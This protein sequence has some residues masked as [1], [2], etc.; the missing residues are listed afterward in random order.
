MRILL[1]GLLGV[2]LMLLFLS[3]L[4]P[5]REQNRLRDPAYDL[6]QN[7]CDRLLRASRTST[8]TVVA[9]AAHPADARGYSCAALMG[10]RP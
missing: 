8:D 4:D 2:C 7:A 10:A 6:E 1:Y 5:Q 3:C 9:L